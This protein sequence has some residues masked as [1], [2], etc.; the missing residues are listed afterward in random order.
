VGNQ[1]ELVR[2]EETVLTPVDVSEL[3]DD[4]VRLA[5]A[6]PEFEVDPDVMAGYMREK[7]AGG[8]VVAGGGP[9]ERREENSETHLG[10]ELGRDRHTAVFPD[11]ARAVGTTQRR[12]VGRGD[13]Q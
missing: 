3:V 6:A 5:R 8:A 4:G 9:T 7:W 2:T 1:A 10:V 11:P 12:G 13:T